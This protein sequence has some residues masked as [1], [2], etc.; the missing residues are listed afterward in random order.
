M[1]LKDYNTLE[2]KLLSKNISS[3][4]VHDL[5]KDIVN[6]IDGNTLKLSHEL[7]EKI[8]NVDAYEDFYLSLRESGLK[9]ENQIVKKDGTKNITMPKLRG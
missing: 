3:S 9:V 2:S 1:K 5:L 8:R 6:A 4:I 7:R